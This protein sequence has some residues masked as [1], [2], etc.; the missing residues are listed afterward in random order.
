ML[1]QVDSQMFARNIYVLIGGIFVL[2]IAAIVI[3]ILIARIRVY[4][5]RG[6]VKRAQ[7][8]DYKLKHRS[9]GQPFPPFGRG[10]CDSCQRLSEK[11][12][13]LPSGPRLCAH[14]YEE[15][16]KADNTSPTTTEDL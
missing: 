10:L 5:W 12:Y 6:S 9:D 14:C 15:L 8:Q 3:V 11:V 1:C 13:F 4:F 7:R 16:E 2:I